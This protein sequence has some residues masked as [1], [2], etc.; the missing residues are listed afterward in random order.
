MQFHTIKYICLNLLLFPIIKRSRVKSEHIKEHIKEHS[1][2]VPG[3]HLSCLITNLMYMIVEAGQRYHY[4]IHDSSKISCSEAEP[5]LS[6]LT[7][8]LLSKGPQQSVLHVFLLSKKSTFVK[9]FLEASF[10]SV[11]IPLP[12]LMS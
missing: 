11:P 10:S 5:A 8:Q 4:Y 7:A 1:Q 6:G 12:P 3:R 2:I 9:P